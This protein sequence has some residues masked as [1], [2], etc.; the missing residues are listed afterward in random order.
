[1]WQFAFAIS[2]TL[3]SK[4]VP[5]GRCGKWNV[6]QHCSDRLFYHHLDRQNDYA[7][8][9]Q[10]LDRYSTHISLISSFSEWSHRSVRCV[11]FN[12]TAREC[13]VVM[14]S[15]ASVCV[16]VCTIRALTFESFDLRNLFWYTGRPTSSKC[17]GLGQDHT[18]RS[19]GQRQ[20]R[21]SKTI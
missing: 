5:P 18:P 9:R 7:P 8:W 10:P 6:S 4:W 20:S 1:M 3:T 14:V 21:K 16:S 13:C 19:S 12:F 17:L 2:G 11:F 15:S